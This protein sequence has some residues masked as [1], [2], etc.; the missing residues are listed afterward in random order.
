MQINDG[1]YFLMPFD[2]VSRD[3]SL[4]CNNWSQSLKYNFYLNLLSKLRLP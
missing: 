3:S 4:Y 1:T 2:T